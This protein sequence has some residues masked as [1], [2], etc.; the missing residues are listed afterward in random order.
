MEQKNMRKKYGKKLWGKNEKMHNKK[1]LPV[2][3][4]ISGLFIP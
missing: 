1:R 2:L 4:V 3:T